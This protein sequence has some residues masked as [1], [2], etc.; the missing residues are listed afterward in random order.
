MNEK[1]YIYT[2]HKYSKTSLPN[3]KKPDK[4]D[5]N[6]HGV[7]K[8]DTCVQSEKKEEKAPNKLLFLQKRL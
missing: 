3:H 2:Y 7:N 5:K 6:R 4:K 8:T 1:R